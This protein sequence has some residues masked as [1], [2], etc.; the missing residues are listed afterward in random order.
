MIISLLI[1][2]ELSNRI[3]WIGK[4]VSRINFINSCTLT[5]YFFVGASDIIFLF[6]L[7]IWIKLFSYIKILPIMHI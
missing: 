6:L 7:E 2:A 3:I 5:N 1:T 4:V